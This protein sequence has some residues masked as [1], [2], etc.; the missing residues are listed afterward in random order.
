MRYIYLAL[1]ILITLAVVT[2]K[3][4]NIETVTVSFL[5][6]SLTV[7]LSFLVSGVY[8]LGMLTGGLVI[9]LVRSLVRGA[10]KPV[11]PRQ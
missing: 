8:F 3:V 5:S 11:Q 10:T 1:I 7:P 2:F 6:S 4:Q 9:S